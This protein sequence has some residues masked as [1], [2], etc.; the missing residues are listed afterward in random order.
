VW[1]EWNADDADVADLHRFLFVSAKNALFAFPDALSWC[2]NSY[3]G[4]LILAQ[5]GEMAISGE[6]A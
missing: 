2:L 5:S 3:V 4:I 6:L 1:A